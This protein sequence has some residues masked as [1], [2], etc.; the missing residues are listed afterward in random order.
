MH[1]IYASG[2]IIRIAIQGESKKTDT[3]VIHLNIKCISF[4]WLTLYMSHIIT[5]VKNSRDT[6]KLYGHFGPFYFTWILT[7]CASKCDTF[8]KHLY[9]LAD[10]CAQRA[11]AQFLT[12]THLLNGTILIIIVNRVLNRFKARA[13]IHPKKGGTDSKLGR[14]GGMLPKFFLN[15]GTWLKWHF[16]RFGGTCIKVI[17]NDQCAWS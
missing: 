11:R 9:Y 10:S 1:I 8:N 14:S 12:Q 5:S 2:Y 7:N 3:F 4:F 17:V 15:F 13:S 16:K 6:P